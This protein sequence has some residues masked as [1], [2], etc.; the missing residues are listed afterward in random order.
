MFL[1]LPRFQILS[2]LTFKN[3]SSYT[4]QHPH[5]SMD[6]SPSHFQQNINHDE[7]IATLPRQFDDLE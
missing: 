7:D 1:Q 5:E 4:G 6:N 3:S 2:V